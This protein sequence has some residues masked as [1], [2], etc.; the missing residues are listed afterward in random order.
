MPPTSGV[1]RIVLLLNGMGER[2]KATFIA[3]RS[4]ATTRSLI[5]WRISGI[6]DLGNEDR[7]QAGITLGLK[8][9]HVLHLTPA[10]WS[11]L[12]LFML[13]P[14]VWCCRWPPRPGRDDCVE[15]HGKIDEA[16]EELW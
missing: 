5:I 8:P 6:S 9:G 15:H 4:Q 11:E 2:V 13:P 10:S 1:P 12:I 3:S 7:G 16:L 14:G